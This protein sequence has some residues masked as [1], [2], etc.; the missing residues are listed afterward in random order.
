M[1]LFAIGCVTIVPNLFV[2]FLL[3]HPFFSLKQIYYLSFW[4]PLVNV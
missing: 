2:D 4:S 3:L 1:I